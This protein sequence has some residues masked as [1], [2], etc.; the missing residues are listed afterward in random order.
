MK[1]LLTL[2]VLLLARAA[3]AAT[4]S[5]IVVDL[6]LDESRYVCGERVRGVVEIRNMSPDTLSVGYPDSQD[7][8]FIELHRSSDLHQLDRPEGRAFVA[9]FRIK[10]N[11]GLKLEV[12]LGDIYDFT[13]QGNFQARPVLVHNGTRY[14][15]L[16]RA[17]GVEPGFKM[18][19]AVQMFKNRDNL[20]RVFE[21]VNLSRRGTPHLFLTARDEGSSSSRWPTVDL[22]PLLRSTPPTVSILAGGEVIVIHRNAPD[23]FVRSEFWSMPKALD[24]RTRQMIRDPETAG[25]Q[26][27][28]EMY[29]RGDKIKAQPSPWWKFW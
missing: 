24:F 4:P 1:N 21:L 26:S 25:Q 27:V 17:F 29:N 18:K 23:S 3:F 19:S 9:P 20:S 15:G 14:V 7:R 13:V 11:Q 2:A 5:E 10:S 28:R 22:G 6:K 16:P 8:F 12:Y